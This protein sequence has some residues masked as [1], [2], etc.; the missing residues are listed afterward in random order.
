MWTK[1]Q[2]FAT[3][4]ALAAHVRLGTPVGTLTSQMQC[5]HV[6]DVAGL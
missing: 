1:V 5:E 2:A 6:V 4:F 3:C